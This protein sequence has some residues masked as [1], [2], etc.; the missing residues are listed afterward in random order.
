MHPGAI[1]NLVGQP[2]NLQG[3]PIAGTFRYIEEGESVEG[4]QRPLG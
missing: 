1:V 3:A 2:V 4:H